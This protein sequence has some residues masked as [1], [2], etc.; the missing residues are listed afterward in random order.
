MK[1][2]VVGA[3]YAGLG[4]SWYLIQKGFE[5]TVF[6]IGLGASIAST[7]LLHPFPGKEAKLSWRAYEGMTE[8]SR[9][10]DVSEKALGQKVCARNGILRLAN[11]DSQMQNWPNQSLWISDGI[12]V[13]SRLYLEGLKKACGLNVIFQ[14]V[15]PEDLDNFDATVWASGDKTPWDFGFK[16][17]IGQALLC[18]VE[19][20]LSY[21]I[22]KEG[23]ISL[24]ENPYMVWVGSTY[25]HTEHPDPKKAMDLIKKVA[26][27]Y[28]QAHTFQ[29]I[30]I[31]SGVRISPKI[32]YIPTVKAIDEKTWVFT[33][34]GSR[35]LLYHAL[36]A[37]EL[38]EEIVSSLK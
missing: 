8:T 23:H 25:E 32:G 38:S 22:I 37:K 34:F 2:A 28:P 15:S 24:T 19:E 18:K 13:F 26:K 20:P 6:D 35:G 11:T 9:L 36:L 5:V 14:K 27:F 7:G 10:L 12:T 17:T 4:I 1:V 21:S 33:G 3:G 16:R 30:E 31:V 29:P